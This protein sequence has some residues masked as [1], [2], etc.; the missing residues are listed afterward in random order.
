[1]S[2]RSTRRRVAFAVALLFACVGLRTAWAQFNMSGPDGY[3]PF[4]YSKRPARWKAPPVP[5]P[6]AE[7]ASNR[8]YTLTDFKP[9]SKNLKKVTMNCDQRGLPIIVD[10]K[11]ARFALC[12]LS[13]GDLENFA[14]FWVAARFKTFDCTLMVPRNCTQKIWYYVY[15]DDKKLLQGDDLGPDRQTAHITLNVEGVR[16]LVIKTSG[17]LKTENLR[18]VWADPILT[19]A[20]DD[21]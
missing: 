18:I 9:N 1:M 4:T 21:E 20:R 6:F 14:E 16:Q 12:Y 8:Y 3:D 2:G 5:K 10:G 17:N 19:E 13:R 7:D 11:P 15:G